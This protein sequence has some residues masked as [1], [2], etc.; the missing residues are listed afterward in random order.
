M[1]RIYSYAQLRIPDF[2]W[3]ADS[4]FIQVYEIQYDDIHLYVFLQS[5]VIRFNQKCMSN[6]LYTHTFEIQ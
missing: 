1:K 5:I 2:K 6:V 3:N 4:L